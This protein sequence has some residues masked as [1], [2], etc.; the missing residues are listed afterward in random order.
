MRSYETLFIIRPDA[1]EDELNSIVGRVE[2]LI[3]SDGGTVL[4]SE[5]WGRRRLAY[6]VKKYTDGIYVRMNFEALPGVVRRIRDHFRV[7]EDII[8]DIIVQQD[9]VQRQQGAS[10]PFAAAA[11][12]AEQE[13]DED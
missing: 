8:R 2:G 10:R 1:E 7:S 12:E 4:Q 9:W 6:E 5:I 13:T 11:G 3:K